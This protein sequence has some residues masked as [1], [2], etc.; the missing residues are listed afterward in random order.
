MNP[1]H[2]ES[3]TAGINNAPA[4]THVTVP[5]SD[6]Q[7]PGADSTAKA[8]ETGPH[9]GS[10]QKNNNG[11][12]L[13]DVTNIER[14]KGGTMEP[15][16]EPVRAVSGEAGDA[17]A[18]EE[19]KPL[20]EVAS[21]ANATDEPAA[22][23]PETAG[24]EYQSGER[25]KP[26]AENQNEKNGPLYDLRSGRVQGSIWDREGPSGETRFT[27]SLSRSYKDKEGNWQ[28]VS[29]FD[30]DDLPHVK[31]VLHK[32]EEILKEELGQTLT[33]EVKVSR[34][35]EGKQGQKQSF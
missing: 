27:L 10:E 21:K 34:K 29:S 26:M 8:A 24:P 15:A 4:D 23:S 28:R 2:S 35:E 31:E 16:S 5:F 3:Q 1:H 14:T 6:F 19:K 7:F 9:E 30:P 12:K 13:P 18:G 20:P 32:A 22:E 25:S 17:Q 11:R 33:S